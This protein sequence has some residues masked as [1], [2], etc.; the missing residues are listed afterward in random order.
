[1]WCLLD[2]RLVPK[3][4]LKIFLIMARTKKVVKAK[5]P[6]KLWFKALRMVI[7]LSIWEAMCQILIA[8]GIC[9]KV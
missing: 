4:Y 5:E 6:V 3:E 9:M 2:A 7:K 1:M 8:R